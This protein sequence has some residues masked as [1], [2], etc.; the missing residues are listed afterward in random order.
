MALCSICQDK[1]NENIN[2]DDVERNEEE[3]GNSTDQAGLQAP[4]SDL[5]ITSMQI[6]YLL[7]FVLDVCETSVIYQLIEFDVKLS[8]FVQADEQDESEKK[9][10]QEQ[11][12]NVEKVAGTE[13]TTTDVQQAESAQS[14]AGSSDCQDDKQVIMLNVNI[15]R[16]IGKVALFSGLLSM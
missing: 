16:S 11:L 12:D 5:I 4:V 1:C 7:D 2:E 14:V 15:V 8:N 3:T 6:C 9:D 10:Q 13:H